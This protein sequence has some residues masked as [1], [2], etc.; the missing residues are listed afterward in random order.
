MIRKNRHVADLGVIALAASLLFSGVFV[1]GSA[2]AAPATAVTVTTG[3]DTHGNDRPGK[4]RPDKDRRGTIRYVALGDSYAAG[5]V[6]APGDTTCQQSDVSYPEVLDD[7]KHVKLV[8][9]GSCS[10]ATTTDVVGQLSVVQKN[11]HIDLVTVTVGAN[12]LNVAALAQACLGMVTSPECAAAQAALAAVLYPVPPAETSVL[13]ARLATT[14]GAVA[15]AMPRA[16]ILVTGYPYLFETPPVDDENYATVAAVNDA[17]TA[18]NATIAGVVAQVAQ[19]KIDIRYVDVT[20]A[21]TGHGIG[22][23][24][25]WINSAGPEAFHPNEAGY[26]AYAAALEAALPSR[27][28]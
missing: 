10:G 22:S 16:T 27:Q 1:A 3:A 21:F 18:L 2:H 20:A 17:T 19:S 5:L 13:A 28:R 26:R 11:Q 4:D 12:D 8:A 24:E 7:V 6:A 9:D 15:A 25:P 14:F 23:P